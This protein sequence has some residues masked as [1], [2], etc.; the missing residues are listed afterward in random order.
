MR[1]FFKKLFGG[2]EPESILVAFDSIPGLVSEREAA[3][4]ARLN[5]QTDAPKQNI[6]NAVARLRLIVNT[7]AGAEH[8]P[9]IHPRLKNIAKNTLPQYIRAMHTALAKDLPEETEEFYLASVE[10]VKSCLNSMKGPGR[11]LQ[12]VFPDEMKDSRAGIDVIGREI[13]AITA[14]LG[15]YRKERATLTEVRLLHASIHDSMQDL[16]R[17]REKYQRIS[18]RIRET[19]ERIDA[20]DREMAA[21]PSDPRMTEVDAKRSALKE[22]EVQRDDRARAYAALSMTASH[23]LRKAEKIAAK[24]KHPGEMAILK[25]AMFLLS[26]H[27]LPDPDEIEKAMTAASPIAERMIEAGEISLKNKEERAVFADTAH[28]CSDMSRTCS[29]LRRFEENCRAAQEA[30]QTHPL[31]AKSG[32]LAREKAQLGAML[33]KERLTQTDLSEWQEKTKERIPKLREEL[34][35]K[36]GDIIGKNVQF[37]DDTPQPA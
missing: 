21:L 10:C 13:N 8:D 7:I 15:E 14:A 32:S 18:Q 22:V 3:A 11:Y 37:Q 24:Q 12:I 6:R 19:A 35:K 5:E 30:L 23:V 26:D 31:I 16:G 28:F 4:E 2:K 17:A 1:D 33:E 27:E 34:R 36:V 9:E 25:H 29:D 20:I